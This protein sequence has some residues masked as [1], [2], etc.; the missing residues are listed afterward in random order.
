MKNDKGGNKKYPKIV[1]VG[2]KNNRMIKKKRRRNLIA[3]W[4]KK[5]RHTTIRNNQKRRE[6]NSNQTHYFQC[7][8][9]RIWRVA[10]ENTL[11]SFACFTNF[12]C[13]ILR[14]N[15]KLNGNVLCVTRCWKFASFHKFPWKSAQICPSFWVLFACYL[16][17]FHSASKIC[18]S[19]HRDLVPSFRLFA[20]CCTF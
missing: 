3:T 12:L 1:L 10:D 13:G 18:S 16:S 11:D 19:F 6:R 5:K 20:L 9:K 2:K 15:Y 14:S 7:S 17:F 8:H 4:I